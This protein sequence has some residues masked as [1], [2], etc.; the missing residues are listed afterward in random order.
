MMRPEQESSAVTAWLT[1]LDFEQTQC[2]TLAKRVDGTSDWILQHPNFTRW[3]AGR[4]RTPVLWCHG[5]AGPGKSVSTS[6]AIDYLRR[7]EAGVAFVYC[8]AGARP[9]RAARARRAAGGG[10]RGARARS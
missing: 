9:A 1:A 7:T 8:G 4:S 3:V 6:I 5:L 2:S 10:R